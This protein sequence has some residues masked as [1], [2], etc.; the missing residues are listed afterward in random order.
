[1]AKEAST[2]GTACELAGRHRDI[3]VSGFFLKN[4]HLLGFDSPSRN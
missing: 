1:M 3:P 2:Y 4:R